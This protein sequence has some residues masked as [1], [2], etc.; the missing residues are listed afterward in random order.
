MH[1]FRKQ[2]TEYL[3]LKFIRK[4]ASSNIGYDKLE[5][6]AERQFRGRG[7]VGIIR[8]RYS[9]AGFLE[10]VSNG[11]HPTIRRVLC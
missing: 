2:R 4:G 11:K 7:H 9:G 8:C 6:F 3:A 5:D 1:L 10:R